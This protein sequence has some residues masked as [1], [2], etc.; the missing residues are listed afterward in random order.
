LRSSRNSSRSVVVSVSGYLLERMAA[1]C[2]DPSCESDATG[3]VALLDRIVDRY[4]SY[5][6]A[7]QVP[8]LSDPGVPK[9]NVLGRLDPTHFATF[10]NQVDA[11][12]RAARAAFEG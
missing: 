12:R 10:L 2:F 7:S 8:H 6:L 1:D 5:V 4:R 11:A 3:L 9:H